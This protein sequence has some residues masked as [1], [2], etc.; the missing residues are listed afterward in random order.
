MKSKAMMLSMLAAVLLVALPLVLGLR[1]P[2]Y[3]PSQFISELGA[4]DMPGRSAANGAFMLIGAFWMG[5]IEAVRKA[6]EPVGIDP[7]VRFGAVAFALS[8]IGS[9]VFPCDIGCPISGSANQVI[10]NTVLWVL[11]AGA[12]V[13]GVRISPSPSI[14]GMRVL[15]GTLVLV[16]LIMQVTAWERQWWPGIWQRLFE[17]NFAILWLLWVWRMP[18]QQA[19]P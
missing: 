13:A 6:Q 12:V 16:F 3:Q 14:K 4:L 7:W 10:H 2:D 15:K 9:V 19:Q 18:T 8:Y 11:N 17:L 5:A 1:V